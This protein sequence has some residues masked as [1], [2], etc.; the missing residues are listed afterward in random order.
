VIF[1]EIWIFFKVSRRFG[2]VAERRGRSS[3][4]QAYWL[5]QSKAPLPS[6]LNDAYIVGLNKFKA[7]GYD[8]LDFV[9]LFCLGELVIP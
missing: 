1:R 2:Q 9:G 8:F 7:A 6:W 5:D 4:V 3:D